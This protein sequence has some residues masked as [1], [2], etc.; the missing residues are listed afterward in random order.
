MNLFVMYANTFRFVTFRL[1]NKT[2]L[3]MDKR[4]YSLLLYQQWVPA[5]WTGFNKDKIDNVRDEKKEKNRLSAGF[6][7]QKNWGKNYPQ[8]L[9]G[10]LIWFIM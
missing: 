8:F 6:L 7:N 2:H 5:F 4:P 1:S 10:K 3:K 9:S